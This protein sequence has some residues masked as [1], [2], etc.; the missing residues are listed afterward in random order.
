MAHI[1]DTQRITLVLLK[2]DYY[3]FNYLLSNHYAPAASEK[4]IL[5]TDSTDL[6]PSTAGFL[7]TLG[8]EETLLQ[9]LWSCSVPD[10]ISAALLTHWQAMR[11]N[12]PSSQWNT[13]HQT[14]LH[15]HVCYSGDYHV[16][17]LAVLFIAQQAAPHLPSV[18]LL[19]FVFVLVL[20]L[21]KTLFQVITVVANLYGKTSGK[22]WVISKCP[23]YTNLWPYS[24]KWKILSV[25]RPKPNAFSKYCKSDISLCRKPF[26]TFQ[27]ST[28]FF[29]MLKY[30]MTLSEKSDDSFRNLSRKYHSLKFGPMTFDSLPDDSYSKR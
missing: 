6:H 15:S 26:Q 18:I 13:E 9:P 23:L 17:I 10:E 28:G 29:L 19:C 8:W 3:Y 11:C 22:F 1:F 12:V 24:E 27:T 14:W 25:T 21:R 4:V 7:L 16:Y 5:H 2:Q 30:K 20:L